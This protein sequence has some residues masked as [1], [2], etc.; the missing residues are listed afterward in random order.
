MADAAPIDPLA[1]LR[2]IHMPPPIETWPP[3]IGWWLLAIFAVVGLFLGLRYLY[4]GWKKGAYRR[5]ANRQLNAL[6]EA[7]RQDQ[8]S[9]LL[10][11]NSLLKRVA[12]TTYPREEV[13]QLTGEAWVAFLDQSGGTHEFTMGPGQVLVDGQYAPISTV[14]IQ[15]LFQVGQHWIKNHGVKHAA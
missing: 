4:L 6:F 11:F 9:F 12:L 13:A 15:N 8:Q 5:E 14:D 2:D 10:E 7:N 3:A 1:E